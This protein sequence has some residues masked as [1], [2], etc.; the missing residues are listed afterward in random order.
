[1]LS[2]S[3]SN[4]FLK[5][6]SRENIL[7]SDL[8]DQGNLSIITRFTTTITLQ[9]QCI[10]TKK[11]RVQKF[12][13]CNHYT[14][15]HYSFCTITRLLNLNIATGSNYQEFTASSSNDITD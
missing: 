8:V 7:N 11:S 9:S 15:S 3:G 2:N 1:M 5:K 12:E 4:D 6:E 14:S 10:E 13:V